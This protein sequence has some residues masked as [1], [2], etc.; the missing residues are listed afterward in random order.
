MNQELNNCDHC[1]WTRTSNNSNSFKYRPSDLCC[2]HPMP[3]RGIPLTPHQSTMIIP[4]HKIT[5]YQHHSDVVLQSQDISLMRCNTTCLPDL[6]PCL[7]RTV[8]ST[9]LT[10][11][12]T[13]TCRALLLYCWR[14]RLFRFF[15]ADEFDCYWVIVEGESN[16][17]VYE[18][19]DLT[20]SGVDVT[21]C[22]VAAC[23]TN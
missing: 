21:I 7:T 10:N 9:S 11:E 17:E 15:L 23:L 13:V 20:A 6:F 8:C 18:V 12:C 2:D 5:A 16:C 3:I 1:Y 22:W 14:V 4:S 19:N